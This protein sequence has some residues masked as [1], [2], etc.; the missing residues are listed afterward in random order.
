MYFR[1]HE[2]SDTTDGL[3]HV[4]FHTGMKLDNII[5]TIFDMPTFY[6]VG[7]DGFYAVR[8]EQYLLLQ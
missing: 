8:E 7:T 5:W 2:Y 1:V 3:K 4:Q 6:T